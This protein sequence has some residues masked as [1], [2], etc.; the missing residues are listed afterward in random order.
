MTMPQ[1]YYLKRT[2][3]YSYHPDY[4]YGSG[5]TPPTAEK[6]VGAI[7]IVSQ[8]AIDTDMTDKVVTEPQKQEPPKA[9]EENKTLWQKVEESFEK[10]AAILAK[11]TDWT[12]LLRQANKF[13]NINDDTAE[14]LTEA[15]AQSEN[16][17]FQAQTAIKNAQIKDAKRQAEI[18][19]RI[20]TTVQNEVVQTSYA[21]NYHN[22]HEDN[23]AEI[24]GTLI[25]HAVNQNVVNATIENMPNCNVEKQAEVVNAV[26]KGIVANKNIND[27]QKV[28]CGIK[29]AR[30]IIQ[31]D[32]SQ[33]AK[34]FESTANNFHN[35]NE[36]VKETQNQVANFATEKVRNEVLQLLKN[37]QYENVKE[38]FTAE[39]IKKA[40]LE[41][42]ATNNGKMNADEA[43]KI[44]HEVEKA[45]AKAE[46]EAKA[47]INETEKHADKITINYEPAEQ[48]STQEVKLTNPFEI[49]KENSETNGNKVK[50]FTPQKRYATRTQKLVAEHGLTECKTA[51]EFVEKFKE[52]S[53]VDKK[54]LLTK[55]GTVELETLFKNTSSATMQVYLISNGFVEYQSNKKHCLPATNAYLE[56]NNKEILQGET[57]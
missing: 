33:Q 39:A 40:Q 23:Q 45:I 52:L 29:T 26:T 51:D 46:K 6:P 36:V 37:S 48:I 14:I 2:E 22:F 21:N 43:E 17:E 8:E 11:K 7:P 49:G 5:M 50:L 18:A 13:E 34:A 57:A 31:L 20:I 54:Q 25:E 30:T 27:A 10:N 1:E 56:I 35:Y 15:N 4:Y 16:E 47:T 53:K 44:R 3:E 32:E 12:W 9:T 42:K 24:A 19:N 41:F 38:S 55:M 28:D